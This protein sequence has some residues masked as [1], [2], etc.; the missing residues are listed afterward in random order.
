MILG[1][2]PRSLSIRDAGGSPPDQYCTSEVHKQEARVSDN[3]NWLVSAIPESGPTPRYA[4][5][6]NL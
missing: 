3:V 6:H 5:I 1:V 2:A 4:F